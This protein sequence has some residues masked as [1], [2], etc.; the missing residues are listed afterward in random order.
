MLAQLQFAWMLVPFLS[1]DSKKSSET[2]TFQT[3]EK[4]SQGEENL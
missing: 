2:T 4:K 3:V 1:C